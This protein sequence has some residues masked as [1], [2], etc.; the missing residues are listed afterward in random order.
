LDTTADL[1]SRRA[2]AGEH[3]VA[4]RGI[5]P[6]WRAMVLGSSSRQQADVTIM[7]GGLVGY[8]ANLGLLWYCAVNGLL[9]P[10]LAWPITLSVLAVMLF[11]YLALR[12]GWSGRLADPG[13]ALP[14]MMAATLCNA[15]GYAVTREAHFGLLM[16]QAL[17]VA[18]CMFSLRRRDVAVLQV[19]SI[20]VFGA[21]STAMCVVD[22]QRYV[23]VIEAGAQG[24]LAAVLLLMTVAGRRVSELR[25]RERHQ[26]DQLAATLVRIEEL[27]TRDALTSLYNRRCIEALLAHRVERSRRYGEALTLIIVDLDHFKR[28]NDACGHAVGD[29]VLRLF[30]ATARK[31][32]DGGHALGRWG[33]EEFLILSALDESAVCA[34]LDRLRVTLQATL[35]SPE[36]PELRAAFS[37]GVAC[38]RGEEPV[39]QALRRADEALYEAK[40]AGRGTTRLAAMSAG[41]SP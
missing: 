5:P 7:L 21:T 16:P 27:A 11:F 12:L 2:A 30:A 39:A 13:L 8:V 28:V 35:V 10:A 1:D 29:E 41:S 31:V 24:L 14:Q 32:F 19:F 34:L 3:G 18:F 37:A 22:P 40:A 26:R 15:V 23:A 25:S 4:L 20:V 6:G 36:H 17:T 33:G 38:V 9:E